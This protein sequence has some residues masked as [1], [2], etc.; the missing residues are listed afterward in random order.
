MKWVRRLLY[1]AVIVMAVL[2]GIRYWAMNEAMATVTDAKL[3]Q[4]LG[5]ADADQII[6]E[7]MDYRCYAC[8]RA[9]A[10]VET[11]HTQHPEIKI[12]FRQVP[13]IG[14]VSMNEAR[15][16]LAAGMGGKFMEMHRLLIAR[17]EPVEDAEIDTLAQTVGIDPE[18][19][20]T[21]MKSV[22]VSKEMLI[23]MS[24]AD[25]LKLKGTPG[26]LINGVLY[27]STMKIPT[28]DDLYRVL[29]QTSK[30]GAL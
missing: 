17:E 7:F 3:G 21:D 16:A 4:Y 27:T 9:H 24:A 8:R 20:R 11:L 13:V 23:S 26:F 30:E 25:A 14:D 19:L 10:S 29:T 18:Q 2:V 22:E 1:T 5:P 28:A 12:V 15:I 6:V